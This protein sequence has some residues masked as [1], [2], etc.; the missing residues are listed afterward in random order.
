M[1][2]SSPENES[3]HARCV[4]FDNQDSRKRG[5]WG[6]GEHVLLHFRS[7]LSSSFKISQTEEIFPLT[8]IRGDNLNLLMPSH[9]VTAGENLGPFSY[10]A[11]LVCIYG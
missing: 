6:A 8:K 2:L 11:H 5:G 1:V 10:L 9:T 7:F 3:G 4:P